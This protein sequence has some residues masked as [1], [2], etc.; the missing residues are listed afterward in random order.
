MGARGRAILHGR[1]QQVLAELIADDV[2]RDLQGC[3]KAVGQIPP[4]LLVEYVASTFIL[5]LNWWVETNSP[6][7]PNKVNDLFRTLIL[8]TLAVSLA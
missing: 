6:L 1:L 7:P 4:A 8:P 5:V 3:R 2:R